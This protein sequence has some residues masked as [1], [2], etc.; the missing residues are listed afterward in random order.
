MVAPSLIE[1]YGSK[2][3][4]SSVSIVTDHK[5]FLHQLKCSIVVR[6]VS[7]CRKV[8]EFCRSSAALSEPPVVPSCLGWKI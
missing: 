1:C 6:E 4:R 7:K 5:L 2:L 8:V 3:F